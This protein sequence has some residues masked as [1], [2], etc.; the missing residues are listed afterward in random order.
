MQKFCVICGA[1]LGQNNRFCPECGKP[2]T[3]D[4]PENIDPE[5]TPAPAVSPAVAPSRNKWIK[6][7][8][9]AIA[10]LLLLGG[11]GVGGFFIFNGKT[12]PKEKET[13]TSFSMTERQKN[14]T[15]SQSSRKKQKTS[16]KSFS[17]AERQENDPDYQEALELLKTA[18]LSKPTVEMAEAAALTANI[19]IL[20]TIQKNGFT[21]WDDPGII[22]S[23][24]KYGSVALIKKLGNYGGANIN[25]K[26]NV[27][28]VLHYA[29]WGGNLDVV[30]YL[31]DK[32]ADINAKTGALLGMTTVLH[33][34]A[35]GG[36]PEV[37]KFLVDKGADINAKDN[38]GYTVLDYTSNDEVR[39][40]LISRGAKSG[41]R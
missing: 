20:E 3:I 2:V 6:V 21:Q 26:D 37:V 16:E 5:I 15:K 18:D 13:S 4:A 24:A 27:S 14:E 28:T 32:G 40:Y 22:L 1:K 9:D 38:D 41:K 29:A 17:M 39:N 19:E 8:I 36:N 34:A 31:V 12:S 23:A 10:A 30:K 11:L 25:A 33:A 7:T 35:L